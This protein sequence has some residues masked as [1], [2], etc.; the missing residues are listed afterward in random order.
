MNKLIS[1]VKTD[2]GN[3]FNKRLWLN[4][5]RHDLIEAFKK[6]G[7]VHNP[8]AIEPYWSVTPHTSIWR[9]L[10]KVDEEPSGWFGISGDHPCDYVALEDVEHDPRSIIKHFIHQWRIAAR[11][12]KAGQDSDAFV[13]KTISERPSIGRLIDDRADRL[14]RWIDTDSLWTNVTVHIESFEPP[15]RD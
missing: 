7:Q 3:R 15:G 12:L 5:R 10:N 2:Y 9:V 6:R 1:S 4:D 8:I 14:Q 13:I 11:D